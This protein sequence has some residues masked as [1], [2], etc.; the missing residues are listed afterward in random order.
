[1]LMLMLNI[2]TLSI[3]VGVENVGRAVV[4]VTEINGFSLDL[5]LVS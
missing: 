4:Q 2:S 1:M 5:F 3:T